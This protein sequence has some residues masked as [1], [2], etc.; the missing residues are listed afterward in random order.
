MSS[1]VDLPPAELHAF[2]DVAEEE[3]YKLPPGR[4]RQRM[5]GMAYKMRATANLAL[6]LGDELKAEVVEAPS[7]TQPGGDAFGVH[8]ERTGRPIHGRRRRHN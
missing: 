2:A 8:R 7:A 5:L 6:W 4:Q 3:A 1:I